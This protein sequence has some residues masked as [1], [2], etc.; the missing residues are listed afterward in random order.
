[1]VSDGAYSGKSITRQDGGGKRQIGGRCDAWGT[2]LD[3]VDVCIDESK[4]VD[5]RIIIINF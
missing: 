4:S 1:M 5:I 2:Q 3:S